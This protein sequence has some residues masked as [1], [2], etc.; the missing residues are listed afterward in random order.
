MT[1]VPVV[2]RRRF[3]QFSGVVAARALVGGAGTVGLS[4]LLASDTQPSDAPVL[5]LVTLYGG[6]DGL[7]T[8]IPTGDRA[9]QDSRPELAYRPQDVLDL[10][11][12]LGLNPG[13][14][15]LHQLWKAG[16]LGI[17][18][19]V[20]YPKPDH[21]HFRSMAIWQT[22]SPNTSVATGWLGRWLDATGND[23]VRAVSLESTLPPFLAGERTAGST[24]RPEGLKLP[25]SALGEAYRKL[26]AASPDDSSAAARVAGSVTDLYSVAAAVNRA[27]SAPPAGTG[28]LTAQLAAISGLIRAGVATRVYSTSL[29]GFD[30]HADERGTQ[31]RL[32][33]QLDAA[34]GGFVDGLGPAGRRVVTVVYS[35]F[36]RRV[37][38]NASQGTDH[39]T[40]GPV[41]VLGDRVRGGFSGEQPGL[42][43]LDNG[44]LKFTT[45]FRDVY[46]SLLEEVLGADAEMVL[47]KWTGRVPLL[48]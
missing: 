11:D 44:D 17:V 5:V 12:G 43:D 9:Y 3:L 46:A 16:R 30:T 25:T 41:L 45:D 23:P 40:A 37:K 18:R 34:L 38:A 10:G 35:E 31:Q 32:L 39:G 7:N 13:M 28:A 26:G 36:G 47:G 8:V 15:R 19:G 29:G 24:I 14:P 6:N 20:G 22:A 4:Q 42:S 27:L 21:S 33:G 1:D 2:T 48:D